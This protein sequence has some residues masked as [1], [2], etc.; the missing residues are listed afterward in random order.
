M[1][2][3]KH[4]GTGVSHVS[5][6][7]LRGYPKGTARSGLGAKPLPLRAPTGC[8]NE[9]RGSGGADRAGPDG[10]IGI[11]RN[12]STGG[13]KPAPARP[14]DPFTVAGA[15]RGPVHGSRSPRRSRGPDGPNGQTGRVPDR[16]AG[17][18]IRPDDARGPA[19]RTPPP[20]AFAPHRPMAP[21]GA[22]LERAA[23]PSDNGA[24]AG[25]MRLERPGPYRVRRTC[26]RGTF[27]VAPALRSGASRNQIRRTVH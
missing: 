12:V 1:F 2:H 8:R 24:R 22:E 6:E 11:G 18:P 17:D 14:E 4:P 7:T 10:R 21:V 5:R 25:R 26:F 20:L 15:P 27:P 23:P 3:V 19:H 9:P 13:R 16:R